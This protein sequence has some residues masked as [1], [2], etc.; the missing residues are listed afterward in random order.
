MDSSVLSSVP[1]PVFDGTL[2][3]DSPSFIVLSNYYR[4]KV[5]VLK[6]LVR[7]NEII[8]L[9]LSRANCS[10]YRNKSFF[11]LLLKQLFVVG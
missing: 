1:F 6:F 10:L 11:K 3:H 2:F 5:K 4:I 9:Y 7:R 8:R